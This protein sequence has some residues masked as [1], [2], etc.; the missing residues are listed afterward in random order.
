MQ[1]NK[2]E[3]KAL[4]YSSIKKHSNDT[5]IIVEEVK[6]NLLAKSCL[7]PG[8]I[9]MLSNLITSHDIGDMEYKKE[10]MNEYT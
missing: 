9:S 7:S 3:S 1:L 4:Y 8:I 5:L 2:P 10:W 6:M